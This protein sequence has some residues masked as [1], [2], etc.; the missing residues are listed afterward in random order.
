L[1][2]HFYKIGIYIRYDFLFVLIYE[3]QIFINIIHLISS[4][5]WWNIMFVVVLIIRPLNK[6][7]SLSV[8]LPKFQK[9]IL[10]SSIVSITS[11]LILF[12]INTGYQYYK[13]FFTLWGN[14][15]LISG[16]LSLL[17][18]YNILSGGRLRLILIRLKMPQKFYNQVPIM[19]FCMITISLFLMILVSKL[20]IS[21]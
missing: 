1:H 18:F 2:C 3:L 10:Y 14:I 8:I 20:S 17:V 19:L 4:F 9:I 12:G 21:K 15:I 7:G 13:L 5:M 11:G 16:I 6:T